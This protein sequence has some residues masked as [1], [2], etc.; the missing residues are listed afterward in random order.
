MRKKLNNSSVRFV[1]L[2]L[3]IVLTF[4][5]LP[6]NSFAVSTTE[7]PVVIVSLG[8][9]Y[10]SG[11]GIEPFYG[12]DK[13]TEEKVENRDWLAHRSKLAWPALLEIPGIDGK[14]GDHRV[15]YNPIS[16]NIEWYFMAVSGAETRHIHLEKQHKEYNKGVYG[17]Y[18]IPLH[19]GEDD[20]PIQTDIFSQ[21]DK[22][23]DYVTMTIGGNDVGFTDIVKT[24]AVNCSYLH[25]GETSKLEDMF[26]DLWKDFNSSDDK[27][28]IRKKIKATYEAI[29]SAAPEAAI[30]IA[31]YPKLL[32][33]E[34]K[35]TV[36]NLKE[37]TL[38]NQNVS[39]FNDEIESIVKECAAGGMN[40]YFVDVEAEFDKD[41]GHQAYSSDSWINKIKFYTESED[42]DDRELASSYSMHPNEKGAEAYA[43]CVNKK[44]AEIE[45]SKN[46]GTLSGKVCKASDMVTPIPNAVIRVTGSMYTTDIYSDVNGNY[47]IKVPVDDYQVSVVAQGYI[48]FNALTT[49]EKD[50]N[51]YM[52]TF[53]M[54][55]GSEGD[56]GTATGNITNALT[57][58]GLEG[59][60]LEVRKAWNNSDKGSVI[61]TT[62]TDSYGN[63]SL[64]LPIGNYTLN[65]SKN[66]YV[67]TMINIVVQKGIA[68]VKN[69]S[70]SPNVSGDN[71]RIVLTWGANPEDVDSHVQGKL[72][73]GYSFHVY[74]NS[75]YAY[76]GSTEVCNLDVD[77]TTSF[78]PET[79]TLNLT[80]GD[81][82]YYY[83]H[84]YSGYG[85]LSS[86]SAQ[87]KVYQGA[88]L[89]ATFN[90]PTD[91][92]SGDYWNV[93]A[94]ENGD[95]RIKNTVT[96][97]PDTYY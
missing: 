22:T 48:Q 6:I 64:N 66:G 88:V 62:I 15:G 2:I 34:G 74:F 61:A 18:Y 37:A 53:L 95:L 67:S 49:V 91:Q 70:I 83:V 85:T 14:T 7:D 77:D 97:S 46:V 69:G 13:S 84:R 60:R 87:V 33:K 27:V 47:S 89:L 30:I 9:S 17:R 31:G 56:T 19:Y 28:N 12:Q 58:Y 92:G 21:I 55:Q 43:R 32:D 72:S 82:Y 68:T 41:G 71:F 76:D 75:P 42:I 16:S 65:A 26:T 25:F 78:G 36:I 1:A 81:P 51:T 93:F 86:S 39:K 4:T 3:S 63:Y 79:I 20:L 8:D 54:V 50:Q 10:S 5:I 90:V 52:E 35:G 80:T 38:V 23:V 45:M 44:I 40:I 24:C 96:T 57:G 94:I 29:E 11:E 59:V 73:D